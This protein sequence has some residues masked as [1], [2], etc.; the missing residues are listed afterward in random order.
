MF[1]IEFKGM[2][3]KGE[4]RTLK[5]DKE[6][7]LS[8]LWELDYDPLPFLYFTCSAVLQISIKGTEHSHTL[9]ADT[10]KQVRKMPCC[11]S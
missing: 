2:C 7:L 11:V 3:K 1:K 5:K 4:N 6:K 10:S 9:F 8:E